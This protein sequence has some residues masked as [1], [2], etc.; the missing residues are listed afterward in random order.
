[1]LNGSMIIC[2]NGAMPEFLEIGPGLPGSRLSCWPINAEKGII[3][4]N[5]NESIDNINIS[6]YTDIA[7]HDQAT[8]YVKQPHKRAAA[9]AGSCF[10]IF[11]N[12]TTCYII[13]TAGNC[14]MIGITKIRGAV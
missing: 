9:S 7:Y 13:I 10:L 4:D 6:I 11:D 8:Y 12:I 3:V 1:M 5:I 14:P 2:R